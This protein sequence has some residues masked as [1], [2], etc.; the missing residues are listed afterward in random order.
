MAKAAMDD[1]RRS[2]RAKRPAGL[3]DASTLSAHERAELAALQRQVIRM[4]YDGATRGRRAQGWRVVSTDANAENLPALS[5]LRDVA[6]DMVR[7]NPH[8]ARGKAVLANNI[9][10]NEGIIPA[11]AG[12]APKT[13]K[14]RVQGLIRAHL[15]TPACDAFGRMN[16]YGLQHLAMGTIV[17][18]GEVLL[19]RRRRFASD[20]LPLPFQIE[21]LEPDYLDS[22]KDGPM[23]NGNFAI[24]GVEFDGQGRKV[25]YWLYTQ[26]PGSYSGRAYDSARVPAADI[27]HVFRTDR[28]GQARGVTWFAPVIL[29]MR[30]LADY[31]DAQLLRQKIAACFAVFISAELPTATVLGDTSPIA[32][33]EDG[34]TYRVESLEPG[35]IQRLKPGEE[36]TFGSPPSVGDF[37]AY[38]AAELRDI[39]VGLGT[40]YEALSGDLT[41]VNFSSGRMGWLEFQ[42]GIGAAQ[43]FMLIPQLCGVVAKWFLEAASLV[44]ARDLSDV[45]LDWTPPSREMINPKEEIGAARDAIRAGLSSRSNEQ[46][47]LGFDPEELDAE[48]AVDSERA[49]ELGLVFDSDP[50][51]RTAAG[52]AVTASAPAAD[53]V[54]AEPAEAN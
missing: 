12:T 48:N 10:G 5:R 42:R 24:Q 21:V 38:K 8:A 35:M 17:E 54:Q 41:G 50:R 40:S 3:A 49:D 15:D 28:P 46:R 13:V 52:N 9:V 53:P 14:A 1:R 2:P 39:A 30:D 16:L 18:S 6:R 33:L 20:G 11:V 32:A 23:P 4:A 7:N 36:V 43:R 31:S 26:H 47:K 44:L 29:K 22:T 45:V 19:R 37:G 51:Q 27:A 25:A 34:A